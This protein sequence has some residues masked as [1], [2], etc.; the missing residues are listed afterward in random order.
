MVG[1]GFASALYDRLE[2][3][4]LALGLRRLF[5]EASEAARQL[6]LRKGFKELERRE[7]LRRGTLIHN[8]A[9]AKTLGAG[10]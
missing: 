10:A 7:F 4:A 2:R 1:R 5:V 3:E 9:M 6:F 8:Y